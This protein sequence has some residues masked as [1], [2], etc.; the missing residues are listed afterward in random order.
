MKAL[1]DVTT[2]VVD[3]SHHS[4]CV[5]WLSMLSLRDNQPDTSY[6]VLG[7]GQPK[8]AEVSGFSAKGA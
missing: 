6:H 8:R 1:Q 2:V 5:V 3:V 4:G 7:C